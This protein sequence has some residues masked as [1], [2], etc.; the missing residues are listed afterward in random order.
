C[1][2]RRAIARRVYKFNGQ[3]LHG[4]RFIETGNGLIANNFHESRNMSAMIGT[5]F[6]NISI[7]S[8]NVGA[9]DII[10]ISIAIMISGVAILFTT[11]LRKGRTDKRMRSIEARIDYRN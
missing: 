9:Y 2:R 4:A 3:N 8:E 1:T 11:V 6:R 5:F 7:A 10:T